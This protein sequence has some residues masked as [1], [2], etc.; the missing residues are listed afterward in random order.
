[1]ISFLG[2]P[3]IN[4][5][6][7]LHGG[8]PSE[9]IMQPSLILIRHSCPALCIINSTRVAK[10]LKKKP[11]S[12]RFRSRVPPLFWP[13]P[14]S[15]QD[16]NGAHKTTEKKREG[17]TLLVALIGRCIRKRR[18]KGRREERGRQRR[19]RG[20]KRPAKSLSLRHLLST[21]PACMPH[22]TPTP[23][24]LVRGR[25]ESG[26]PGVTQPSVLGELRSSEERDL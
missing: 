6:V 2:Q 9:D 7:F 17:G 16:Q 4:H 3:L 5:S 24:S 20:R 15:S 25:G 18:K 19:E 8:K 12:T 11:P 14:P 1:M 23:L 21:C 10:V 26:L 22:S 13:P